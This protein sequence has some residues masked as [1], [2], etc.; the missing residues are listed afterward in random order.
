MPRSR[1]RHKHH[2][3]AGVMHVQRPAKT[4]RRNAITI[5]VIFIGLLGF[6]VA[7]LAA[8]SEPVWLIAGASAGGVVGYFIG[9]GMN[10]LAKRTK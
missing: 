2:H 9:R 3:H 8:G 4:V 1:H 10:E 6:G 5:M 7:F